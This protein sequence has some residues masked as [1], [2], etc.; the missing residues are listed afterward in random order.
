MIFK[1]EKEIPSTYMPNYI[2]PYPPEGESETP[3][4]V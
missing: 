4:C 2:P 1:N 3:G